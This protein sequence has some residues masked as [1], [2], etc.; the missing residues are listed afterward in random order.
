MNEDL[1]YIELSNGKKNIVYRMYA[2]SANDARNKA[3][4]NLSMSG[5][6]I[7]SISTI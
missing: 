5:Y 7:K 2:K 3:L 4:K 6:E 1:Y